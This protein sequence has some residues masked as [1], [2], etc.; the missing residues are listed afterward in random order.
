MIT[1]KSVQCESKSKS[2]DKFVQSKSKSNDKFLQS[3]SESNDNI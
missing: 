3:K 1:Y 2:N